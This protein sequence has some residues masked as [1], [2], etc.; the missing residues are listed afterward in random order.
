MNRNKSGLAIDLTK[1]EGKQLFIDLIK[2][3]DALIE[4]YSAE[5]LPKLGLDYGVLSR[6]NPD[7]LM[8][9]IPVI[10]KKSF[11][12]SPLGEKPSGM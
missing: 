11:T 1:S 8:L 5:V 7:L 2:Q 3:S 4:N 6:A 9:S 12:P 10:S